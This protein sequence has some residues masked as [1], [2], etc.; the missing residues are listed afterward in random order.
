MMFEIERASRD[1]QCPACGGQRG[2]LDDEG[3]ERC[4]SCDEVQP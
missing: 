1:I 3:K 4:E 2:Y